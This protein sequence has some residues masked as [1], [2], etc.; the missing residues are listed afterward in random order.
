MKRFGPSVRVLADAAAPKPGEVRSRSARRR[1]QR[2]RAAARVAE[3]GYV[4]KPF[5]S[6]YTRP[7]IAEVARAHVEEA[8]RQQARLVVEPNWDQ[9]SAPKSPLPVSLFTTRG[10]R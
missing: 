3:L 5:V 2:E 7:E 4:P 10:S 9:R 1:E 6:Y 8:P